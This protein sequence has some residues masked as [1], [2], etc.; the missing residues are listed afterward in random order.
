MGSGFVPV[1]VSVQGLASVQVLVSLTP[2]VSEPVVAVPPPHQ[3][4][5]EQP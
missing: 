5:L 3:T 4:E 1:L 2:E